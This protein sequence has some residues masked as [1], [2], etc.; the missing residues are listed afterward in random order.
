MKIR[1]STGYF[2][3]KMHTVADETLETLWRKKK[4]NSVVSA[5]KVRPILSQTDHLGWRPIRAA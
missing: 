2:T 4:E 5:G 3:K 1:I